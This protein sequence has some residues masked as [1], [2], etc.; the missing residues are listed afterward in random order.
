MR[1]SIKKILGYNFKTLIK[2]ELIYK[3]LTTIIFVPI[4]LSIFHFITKITGYNYL[5][6]ENIVSFLLNPL[7]LLFLLLLL[8]FITFY[9]IIDISTIIIILDNSYI[10]KKVKVKEAFNVA[11]TKSLRIFKP[12]N[13]LIL[14]LVI[15]LIPFLNLGLSSS[16]IT[17]IK[18][19]E[20][21]T[22][23]IK[24]NMTLSILYFIVVI[25]LSIIL[26]RW[27]YALHYFILE[28][29]NFKEARKKSINLSRHNKIKDY[30]KIIMTQL[31]AVLS[32]VIFIFLG[33]LIII[34]LYKILNKIT[35]LET[36]SITII[37]LLIAISYLIFILLGTP[38]S[39]AIISILYY[40][41]KEKIKEKVIHTDLKVREEKKSKKIWSILKY[42]VIILVIFSSTLF[43]YSV[44]NGKYDLKMEY[45]RKI[46][47]TAHRGASVDFPENTMASF[48]GAKDLGTDW[49][50]LDVQQTK[51]G[52]IIV[53]HDTN[54]KRTTGVNKRTW[55]LDYKDIE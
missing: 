51:D 1:K 9:T 6:L 54:L 37:W 39:Y 52:Q 43:T 45:I 50:E 49:I 2:F 16:V 53:L 3:F 23:F 42:T 46:E 32:Y 28:D 13:I 5:T 29:C 30:L 20:F 44:L 12:Q 41:H 33:I 14:F 55:E 36:L 25:I 48:R 47:V 35:I 15:F 24:S 31:L 17:T 34:L 8:I 21:I 38:L 19:P 4:F 27:L 26:F 22:D 18:I 11:L 7:T 40:H 10:N